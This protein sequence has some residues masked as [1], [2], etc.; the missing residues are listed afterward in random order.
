MGL[1]FIF[2]ASSEF[3]SP[4]VSPRRLDSLAIFSGPYHPT[5]PSSLLSKVILYQS[6]VLDLY[7]DTSFVLCLNC[8]IILIDQIILDLALRRIICLL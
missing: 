4:S 5:S 6:I 7:F 1:Q 3:D 8:T 2:L